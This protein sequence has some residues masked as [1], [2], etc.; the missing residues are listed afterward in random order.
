L[1]A[2][3]PQLTAASSYIRA[4]GGGFRLAVKDEYSARPQARAAWPF[5][6]HENCVMTDLPRDYRLRWRCNFGYPQ[7]CEKQ[8]KICVVALSMPPDF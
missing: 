1:G 3:P 8:L 4:I 2:N 6:F 7:Q 5:F